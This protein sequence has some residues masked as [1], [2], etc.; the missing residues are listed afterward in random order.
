[1]FSLTKQ[2]SKPQTFRVNLNGGKGELKSTVETPSGTEEDMFIQ[3]LDREVY[4][5]RY[6]F[7]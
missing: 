7:H 5:L 2:L 4:A 3:E 1:M 6:V